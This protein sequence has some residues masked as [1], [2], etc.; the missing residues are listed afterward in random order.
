VSNPSG[1]PSPGG[2]GGSITISADGK[3]LAS[4]E[5]PRIVRMLSSTGADFGC[6]RLSTVVDD[7]PGPFA[8][9][10]T[11]ARVEFAFQGRRDKRDIAVTAR[12][13]MA[14]E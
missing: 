3:D 11:L 10:G 12:A 5:I 9:T 1:I 6:D 2:Q 4:V 13:E 8:F 7:Y 14:K